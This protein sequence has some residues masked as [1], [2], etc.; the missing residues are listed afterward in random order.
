MSLSKPQTFSVPIDRPDIQSCE[1]R[2]L[3]FWVESQCRLVPLI[4][5][6]KYKQ[7]QTNTNT[8]LHKIIIFWVVLVQLRQGYFLLSSADPQPCSRKC[9]NESLHTCGLHRTSHHTW[10]ERRTVS[11]CVRVFA[12][13]GKSNDRRAKQRFKYAPTAVGS[14]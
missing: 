6:H 12:V 4:L 2:G 14:S 1:N 9:T 8:Q 10:G 3:Q 7:Y 11:V 5:K 13:S